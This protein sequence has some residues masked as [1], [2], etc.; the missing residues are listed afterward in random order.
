[1]A[2]REVGGTSTV[3]YCSNYRHFHGPYPYNDYY[4]VP[5]VCLVHKSHKSP[6][7]GGRCGWWAG[8]QK[9][10]TVAIFF[11]VLMMTEHLEGGTAIFF[12]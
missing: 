12:R 6:A 2:T 1:M 7:P 11:S 3:L 9:L 8:S 10:V 5:A 4:N